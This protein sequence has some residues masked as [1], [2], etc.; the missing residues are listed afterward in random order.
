MA[1][2]LARRRGSGNPDIRKRSRAHKHAVQR[3]LTAYHQ[4]VPTLPRRNRVRRHDSEC[5][6]LGRHLASHSWIDEI[7]LVTGRD[8]ILRNS[9][10]YIEAYR[11]L[12]SE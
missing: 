3:K 2:M 1:A 8:L 5:E 4:R 12:T 7:V 9:S 11:R 10:G 6:H